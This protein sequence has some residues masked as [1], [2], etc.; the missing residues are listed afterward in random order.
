MLDGVIHDPTCWKL[1]VGWGD[2]RSNMFANISSD[3]GARPRRKVM[4]SMRKMKEMNDVTAHTP[5]LKRL[6]QLEPSVGRF[7]GW[8]IKHWQTERAANMLA[9]LSDRVSPPLKAQ[10][11]F[12]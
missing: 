4:M 12:T 6:D 1:D 9:N 10:N 7:V 2:T 3:K 5:H 8:N 11:V